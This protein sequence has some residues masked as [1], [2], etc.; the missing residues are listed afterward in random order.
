MPRNMRRFLLLALALSALAHSGRGQVCALGVRPTTYK[1][2]F[3]QTPNT[4]ATE[5][6]QRIAEVFA[7]VCA[8]K[9]PTIPIFTN[10]TAGNALMLASPTSMKFVSSPTFFTAVSARYGDDGV[11]GLVAHEY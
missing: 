8:P 2:N 5:I 10:P 1:S 7:A 4:R 9:C 6:T 3:D 11:F